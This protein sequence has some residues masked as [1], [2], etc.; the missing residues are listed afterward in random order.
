MSAYQDAPR[1]LSEL[2]GYC[3]AHADLIHVRVDLDG[4][5]KK[6][7][8]S[9]IPFSRAMEIIAGWWVDER[10]PHVLVEGETPE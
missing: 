1:S 2:M 9:K 5:V 3:V 10:W 8:L 4:E 6:M 7:P